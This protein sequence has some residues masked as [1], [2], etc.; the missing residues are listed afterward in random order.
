MLLLCV[1][2]NAA[3]F[4]VDEMFFVLVLSEL[5]IVMLDM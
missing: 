3:K 1:Q 2:I 4:D 5:W